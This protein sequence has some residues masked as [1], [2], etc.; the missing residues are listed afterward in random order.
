MNPQ[1]ALNHVALLNRS[2]ENA[3]KFYRD[4]L[5]LDQ[6]YENTISA[7]LAFKIFGI[8]R[9]MAITVFGNDSFRIE[10]FIVDESPKPSLSVNHLCLEVENRQAFVN[11]CRELGVEINTI[12]R[13]TRDLIFI[14]DFDGNLFEIK[15]KLH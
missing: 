8:K 13:D 1:T 3:N 6:L 10:I 14:R 4:L 15:E 2:V 7:D 9:Q 5:N 12:R 11:R